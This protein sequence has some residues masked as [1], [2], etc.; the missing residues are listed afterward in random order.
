MKVRIFSVTL[1]LCLALGML[2]ASCGKDNGEKDNDIASDDSTYV[3]TEEETAPETE[4]DTVETLPPE[5]EPDEEIRTPIENEKA[6]SFIE[7]QYAKALEAISYA[8]GGLTYDM[9]TEIIR[10]DG[11][12]CYPINDI[13]EREELDG[14]Y[15]DSYDDLSEYLRSIFA[16]SIADD[17]IDRASDFYSDADGVLC[18]ITDR[19]ADGFETETD[20]VTEE[21][22]ESEALPLESESKNEEEPTAPIVASAEFFLSEFTER[23]FRY[24]A[25]VSFEGTEEVSYF[26][27][28]FENTG[29]GWY[30][31][32]F[33]ALPQ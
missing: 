29:S 23:L 1:A 10:E 27:F 24:T 18:Y 22:Q 14:G 33:P 19:M 2:F 26:D 13:V 7:F 28:I 3:E 17:L 20:E 12:I 6:L 16:R 21:T 31:T 15:I 32:E 4:L 5:T 8:E 11:R 9:N 30:F 25:K